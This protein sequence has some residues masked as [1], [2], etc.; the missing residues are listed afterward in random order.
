VRLGVLCGACQIALYPGL[1]AGEEGRR[2]LVNFN[3]KPR[4]FGNRLMV[5]QCEGT[6]LCD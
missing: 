1:Q 3:P 6:L 4:T 5:V 2:R